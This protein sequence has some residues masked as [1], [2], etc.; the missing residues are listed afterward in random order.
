MVLKD[1]QLL[2]EG[3]RFDDTHN[4]MRC[5]QYSRA[6]KVRCE[7]ESRSR[8]SLPPERNS[9]RPEEQSKKK[10]KVDNLVL[11]LLAASKFV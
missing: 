5:A 11:E 6:V 8:R 3:L 2:K 9:N 10:Q 1:E 4:R 7:L